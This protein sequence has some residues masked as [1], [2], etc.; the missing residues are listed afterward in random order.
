ME[1]ML[2]QEREIFKINRISTLWNELSGRINDRIIELEQRKSMDNY[3]VDLSKLD[4]KKYV[5]LMDSVDN[6]NKDFTK[7]AQSLGID[8]SKEIDP[9]KQIQK[10][11][12]EEKAALIE[13]LKT[14]YPS[15]GNSSKRNSEE[16]MNGNDGLSKRLKTDKY[17]N[18]LNALLELQ[19]QLLKLQEQ[20][21]QENCAHQEQLVKEMRELLC[22]NES[23]LDLQ[24]EYQLE[25]TQEKY[26][27]FSKLQQLQKDLDSFEYLYNGYKAE[28][29]KNLKNQLLERIK[30][31]IKTQ[32]EYLKELIQL[33]GQLYDESGLY[34][35]ESLPDLLKE[36]LNYKEKMGEQG[37]DVYIQLQNWLNKIS[38]YECR[39]YAFYYEFYDYQQ[40][41][42]SLLTSYYS[43]YFTI[44]CDKI[45]NKLPVLKKLLSI[46]LYEINGSSYF[47]LLI[48]QLHKLLS[49]NQSSGSTH[50]LQLQQLILR[51]Q[52][53]TLHLQK[54]QQLGSDDTAVASQIQQLNELLSQFE[55][56]NGSLYSIIQETVE[57]LKRFFREL[58][59][60]DDKNS[61]TANTLTDYSSPA[62]QQDA[63]SFLNDNQSSIAN[64]I[65]S[66]THSSSSEERQE[67]SA[68]VNTGLNSQN[69]FNT[70]GGGGH[71]S[72]K[73][74][75]KSH[76]SDNT[77]INS[78]YSQG[79]SNKF[80]YK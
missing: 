74:Q 75:Q 27:I 7:L 71:S 76:A 61:T 20:F 30:H 15:E 11:W 54:I 28:Y 17:S 47:P 77:G 63:A 10:E 26:P 16:E 55:M 24:L 72:S 35:Y 14:L 32:N 60:N 44:N 59:Q 2:L 67:P 49:Q 70:I 36:I 64:N 62:Q 41:I 79:S 37:S 29:S 40:L 22:K 5:V 58:N 66:C 21:G 13:Q 46:Q 51:V 73:E 19:E 53:L 50:S 9:V 48:V 68:S 25:V 33:Q 4:K 8:P 43:N 3:I 1:K 18:Y 23:F 45:M 6:M 52:Q 12:L 65:H 38:S 80:K 57:K 39:L 78:Q 31:N 56:E 42:T 69:S 34:S